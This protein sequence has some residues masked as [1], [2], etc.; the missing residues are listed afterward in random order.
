[1]DGKGISWSDFADIRVRTALT[2]GTS[3]QL[4]QQLCG[5]SEVLNST[6]QILEQSGVDTL[7]VQQGI[8][9]ESASLTAS[10]VTCLPMFPFIM[11]VMFLMDCTG[12][13]QILLSTNPV[14]FITLL[15]IPWVNK[16]LL[17]MFKPLL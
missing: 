1:M 8:K 17:L 15:T 2:V 5:I 7:L 14:L 10:T 12:R 13:R 11:L 9:A 16:L 3:L 4:L 6:P